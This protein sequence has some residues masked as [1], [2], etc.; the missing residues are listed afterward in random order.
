MIYVK[1]YS[2]GNICFYCFG[3]Y[4]DTLGRDNSYKQRSSKE[5]KSKNKTE[6]KNL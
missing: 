2:F 5:E 1:L 4:A 6:E 3:V